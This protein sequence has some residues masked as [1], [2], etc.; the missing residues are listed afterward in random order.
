VT[1]VC[2]SEL[3][4]TSPR[5]G[6]G[7]MY[8]CGEVERGD[9][10]GRTLGFPTAN[11]S[12]SDEWVSP[13]DGVYAGFAYTVR[14]EAVACAVSVGRRPTFYGNRGLRLLEAHLLDYSGDLY[15]ELLTVEI[16]AR[17]RDQIRFDGVDEL[18]AQL[19]LDVELS[20]FVAARTMPSG[21]R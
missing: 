20:R 13:P 11:L 3:T 1:R 5:P 4:L 7:R 21:R 19:A 17:L 8:V 12:I 10:R 18:L 6:E 14:R 9:Q 16:I 15:G 2:E